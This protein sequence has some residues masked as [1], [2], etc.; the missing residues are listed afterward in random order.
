MQACGRRQLLQWGALALSGCTTPSPAPAPRPRLEVQAHRGG[1]GLRPENSWPAFEHALA[2]GVDTLELDI[3]LSADDVVVIAHDPRLNPNLV[4][5]P[6]G[7]WVSEPGPTLR[8]LRWSELQAYDI[9]RIRPGTAYARQFPDQVPV[10]G[11]RFLR[12]DELLRRVRERADPRVR[13]NIETKI[14]PD[15]PHETAD[16]ETMVQALLEVIGQAG[17]ASR[18]SIQSFDW[19]TLRIVQAR[20]PAIPTVC[21]SARQSWLDNI[22][23][24]QA[25][26]WSAGLQLRPGESL[27]QLVQ[28]AG[29]AI[30]SPYY[31]DLSPEQVLQAHRLGLQVIPWTVNEVQEMQALRAMQVDG[32]ITDRP[33]RLLALLS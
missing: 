25:G 29:A 12:L 23:G 8:S 1:R 24:P 22:G 13:L 32:I 18:V 17:M 26:R 2:M 27:P 14:R 19:R 30:W 16:P 28:R 3:G 15:Q 6:G 33:D 31:R 5:G 9:G 7:Q 11:T 21:L 20:A 10:D 4:R